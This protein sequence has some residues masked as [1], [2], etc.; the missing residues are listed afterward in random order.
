[1]S[2]PG[3][4][5]EGSLQR[6]GVRYCMASSDTALTGS[7]HPAMICR[8]RGDGWLECQH[9]SGQWTLYWMYA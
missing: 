2:T 3:F 6:T 8:E 4:T 7:V 9:V 5:A 1:M